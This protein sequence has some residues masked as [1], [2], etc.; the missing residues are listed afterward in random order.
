MV[1]Y[2]QDQV[3]CSTTTFDFGLDTDTNTLT[4]NVRMRHRQTCGP[5]TQPTERSRIQ[6]N[7][8]QSSS[9]NPQSLDPYARLDN[10]QIPTRPFHLM[11]V[12]LSCRVCIS[13]DLSLG[14]GRSCSRECMLRNGQ[15]GPGRPSLCIRVSHRSILPAVK[16]WR[17][18]QIMEKTERVEYVLF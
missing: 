4:G 8:S 10:A 9:H 2:R 6:P 11:I 17:R 16:Y 3:E 15:I 12:D 14:S 7:H 5:V 13:V 18:L 1:A